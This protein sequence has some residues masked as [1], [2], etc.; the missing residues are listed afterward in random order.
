[1]EAILSYNQ[2][3]THQRI[4]AVIQQAVLLSFPR[5]AGKHAKIEEKFQVFKENNVKAWQTNS[6]YSNNLFAVFKFQQK[7][8]RTS[9]DSPATFS[10]AY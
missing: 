8:S 4:D 9:C 5:T 7:G 10:K 6:S 1:M 3:R 2:R